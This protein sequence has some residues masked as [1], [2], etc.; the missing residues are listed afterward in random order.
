M[1]GQS[2]EEARSGVSPSFQARTPT[3]GAS[4]FCTAETLRQ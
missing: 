3:S 2:P 1:R 4:S